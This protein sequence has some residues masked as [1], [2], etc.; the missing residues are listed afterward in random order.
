[1]VVH[2]HIP[3]RRVTVTYS[4]A[5]AAPRS[6][7]VSHAAVAATAQ[8]LGAASLIS[9]PQAHAGIGEDI[10]ERKMSELGV[11]IDKLGEKM[12]DCIESSSGRS[13]SSLTGG[14]NC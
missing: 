4:P 1:M 8:S 7:I 14:A 13:G 9:L 2:I 11:K 12:I 6:H 10:F 5:S 3:S